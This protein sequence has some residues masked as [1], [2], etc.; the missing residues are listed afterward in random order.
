MLL[1]S[2]PSRK[3][4]GGGEGVTA[5]QNPST[6]SVAISSRDRPSLRS[7]SRNLAT[8]AT[9]CFLLG[10]PIPDITPDLANDGVLHD[11]RAVHL[12]DVHLVTIRVILR[13]GL[14]PRLHLFESFSRANGSY[15]RNPV[16]TTGGD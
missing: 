7:E 2:M 4:R 5:S 6:M 15:A 10:S 1:R 12:I 3:T 13:V 11:G 8:A 14:D 9:C 16:L